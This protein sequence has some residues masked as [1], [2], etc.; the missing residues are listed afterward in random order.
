MMGILDVRITGE[1]VAVTYDLFEATA[2]QIERDIEQAGAKLG[3]GWAS[4]LRRGWVHY[5]E[6]NELDNL[7]VS[8]MAC[9]NTP[10]AKT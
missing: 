3:A 5:T 4:R 8:N 6:E 10:P 2:E 9:C 7:A 1:K